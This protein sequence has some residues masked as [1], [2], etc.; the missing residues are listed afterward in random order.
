MLVTSACSIG[1]PIVDRARRNGIWF[2]ARLMPLGLLFAVVYGFASALSGPA[3]AALALR[4]EAAVPFVPAA[5]WIYLSIFLV[6][7]LPLL[8][9]E[10][11][12]IAPLMTRYIVVTLVAG[13]LFIA[14]PTMVALERPFLRDVTTIYGLLYSLD[15]PYNAAPSLHVAY[16]VLVLW[17]CARALAGWRRG[18]V[19]LWLALL[20]A[21]TWLTHQHQLADIVAGALLGGLSSLGS[22]AGAGST[23]GTIPSRHIRKY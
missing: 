1:S 13:G 9:L 22:G 8:V 12:S 21:S 15:T 3:P 23:T 16:A 11:S 2:V 4:W 14:F 10:R 20:I 19:L 6:F 18:A 5:I 7:W 17:S